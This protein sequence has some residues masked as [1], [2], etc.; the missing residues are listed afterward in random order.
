[1]KTLTK[2]ILLTSAAFMGACATTPTQ[3]T[4]KNVTPVAQSILD[5]EK[6]PDNFGES[7]LTLDAARQ[8]AVT[9]NKSYRQKIDQMLFDLQRKASGAKSFM[10][11]IYANSFGQWRSNTNASVGVKVDEIGSSMPED[12]Y[13]AQDQS[14]A[15]S[16]LSLSWNLLDVGLMGHQKAIGSIDGYDALETTRLG[17]HQLMV[18]LERAY[19]RKVAFERAVPKREWIGNRIN[20]ALDLSNQHI[21]ENPND[22]LSELMFQRE[23]IDI[24]RWYESMFR[25][26]ASADSDLARLINIPHGTEFSVSTDTSEAQD[27]FGPTLSQ[28]LGD[29]F[30]SAFEN[31][32][33]LRKALY[34]IDRSELETKQALLRHLP[35]LNLFISGNNDTNS[36]ALNQDFL[37][38]GVNLSWD[39]LNLTKIGSTKKNGK[40][41]TESKEKDLGVVASAIMAQIMLAKT[42]VQNLE[43]EMT[44]AWKAKTIQA[45][46]TTKLQDDVAEQSSRET[47][48]VKEELLRELS[49]LRED[50]SQADLKSTQARLQQSL[51][52]MKTCQTG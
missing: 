26:L 35:G 12:F 7:P 18:D 42:E 8:M 49:V 47:Y 1:M 11:Q 28:P 27:E 14:F 40:L 13:T 44:L 33:E 37:T 2:L 50:I 34:N 16:K 25:G 21:E 43:E 24:K 51:G 48:L 45:Q 23:L 4:Q 46:I 10:P 30:L 17:C 36:F 38:A 29:L 52:E 19:W 22:R 31:R 41:N 6:A 3:Y 5:Q 20:Y 32:P 9:R 39:V 15:A